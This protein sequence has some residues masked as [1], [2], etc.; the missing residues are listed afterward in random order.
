[1]KFLD[2]PLNPVTPCRRICAGNS[3]HACGAH[4][5]YIYTGRSA[6]TLATGCPL[7]SPVRDLG[8]PRDFIARGDETPRAHQEG[9]PRAGGWRLRPSRD[10]WAEPLRLKVLWKPEAF[11][12]GGLGP[13]RTE[14]VW[15]A[16]SAARSGPAELRLAAL[17]FGS[18]GP[19]HAP[20]SKCTATPKLVR[21][22]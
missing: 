7:W 15:G 9:A 14:R 1:M 17:L 20:V 6:P 3:G 19:E 18:A 13:P 8:P 5:R 11:P 16:A 10:V 12:L 21:T 4:C 22:E 2:H